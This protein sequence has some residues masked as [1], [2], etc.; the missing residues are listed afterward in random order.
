VKYKAM[1]IALAAC[2]FTVFPGMLW[3]QLNQYGDEF[4]VDGR[5]HAQFATAVTDAA[6]RPHLGLLLWDLKD[7]KGGSRCLVV[8]LFHGPAGETGAVREGDIILAVND[9]VIQ[10]AEQFRQRLE[11]V[12][13]GA[14]VRLRLERAVPASRQPLETRQV[15]LQL[16]GTSAFGM[17]GNGIGG[18]AVETVTVR[19]GSVAEWLTPIDMLRSSDRR[20][21]PEALI[22][23]GAGPTKLE[24][25]LDRHLTGQGMKAPI[26]RLRWYL[27]RSME[28]FYGA[29]MLDRVA[30]AY[31]RPTRLAELQVSIT[32]PLARMV[33]ERKGAWEV[34][35]KVLTEAGR[36]LDVPSSS[37]PE[38]AID[39]SNP[40]SALRQAAQSVHAAHVLLDRAFAKLSPADCVELEAS[41]VR[42]L[43]VYGK[44]VELMGSPIWHDRS[45]IRARRASTLIDYASLFAAASA[46]ARWAPSSEPP[47]PN[48]VSPSAVPK[49]LEG[50]VKGDVLAVEQ[51]DGRWYVYGGHGLN[52]YDMSRIDVVIDPAGDDIYHYPNP[53]RPKVQFVID[54]AGHDL[55]RGENGTPGPG[56]ALLGVN[57]VLDHQGNDRYEGG[58]RSCGV[59]VMGIGLIVDHSGNDKYRGTK[60]SLGAGYYGFGGIVDLQTAG[61]PRGEDAYVAEYFSQGIGGPRGF[62]LLLDE[63]GDDQYRANGPVPY[64]VTGRFEAF[65]QGVGIGDWRPYTGP[66][67]TGGIGVICDLAGNDRYEVGVYGQGFS[68]FVGLGILYD[69]A[70]DDLYSGDRF[71]QAS[72]VHWGIGI[73]ADDAGDD[74]YW[75][76]G[77]TNQ[78]AGSDHALSLLIDRAGND[79]YQAVSGWAQGLSGNHGISWLI[80][81]SGQDRYV[82]VQR[83]P[84]WVNPD[85]PQEAKEKAQIL[86]R[87]VVGQGQS[88]PGARAYE[89]CKC[90]SWSMLLDAGGTPDFYSGV[91][92]HSDGIVKS[93]GSVHST[94]PER[95]TLSGLFIDTPETIRF[96]P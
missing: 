7:G 92:G 66:Y 19:A 77:D 34:A 78:A 70:G 56:S 67:D 37:G 38:T 93:T 23:V 33:D 57:V 80:D 24:Q 83:K 4:V 46:V 48:T 60:W 1:G 94:H 20:V 35:S 21:V 41:L 91:P 43:D 71:S 95:N 32:Q 58:E 5:T 89:E 84:V 59:G 86:S 49:A 74:T 61:G 50:A 51:I 17:T 18:G 3:A 79:S 73:L 31:Y 27:S 88:E 81:L 10:S 9:A 47:A 52:E 14:E 75:G 90:Y 8:H 96:W 22:P 25:F 62:G 69:R 82:T 6:Q 45:L 13:P 36:N 16:V 63:K 29:N 72:P 40:R 42:L 85:A 54:W 11:R 26:D 44:N 30:F 28:R 76:I 12:Q 53:K 87:V 55:Y 2:I 39:L 15:R 64:F 65:S 68:M